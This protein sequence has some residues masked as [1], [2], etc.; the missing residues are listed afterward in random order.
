MQNQ[1]FQAVCVLTASKGEYMDPCIWNTKVLVYHFLDQRSDL[2]FQASRPEY[3][4]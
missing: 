3:L 2:L 1:L 4:H